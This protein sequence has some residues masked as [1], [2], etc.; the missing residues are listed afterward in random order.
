MKSFLETIKTRKSSR[1]FTDKKVP[2]SLVNKVLTLAT[3]APTPCNHQLWDFVVITE[4]RVKQKLV[5]EAASSTIILRAPVVI[6]IS[7]DGWNY[8][9][10]V[11]SGALAAENMHLAANYFGLG[12][13]AM[14]SYGS[15]K[16]IKEILGMPEN[17]VICCF[18][19]LGYPIKE[20]K[21]E[22]LVP[23]VPIKEIIH[24][25]H[26]QKKHFI[27][28][29]Y[30]PKNWSL[31][32]IKNYQERFCRKTWIGKA[33]D[34][35]SQHEL[36]IVKRELQNIK[37]PVTDLFSYDGMYLPYFQTNE[38][39]SYNLGKET[40]LYA[41]KTCESKNTTLK[42]NSKIYD[43]KKSLEKS[44][45]ISL[46]YKLE[47]LPSKTKERVL[48]Q[49]NN[50]LT[51]NGELLII[52]R[53]TNFFYSFF[54]NFIKFKFGDDIRKTG[55]YSFF[56]PYKPLS[57]NETKLQLQKAG[58]T[59]IKIRQYFL[60]PAF[61]EQ[62]Y[63]MYLQW[64]KSSGSTFLHRKRQENFLTKVF[65]I[66]IKVQGSFRMPFGNVVVIKAKK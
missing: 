25:N 31:N 13:L 2:I 26:F 49:A 1:R 38:I 41:K 39:T 16:K 62:A 24:L 23:R 33:M 37:S 10:A 40:S 27:S 19:L 35:L 50:S 14:N 34:I 9:E 6:V 5:N 22:P 17:N 51:Y 42:I 28:Y 58:F 11:Q 43:E 46:I 59:D 61:F 47:R 63:Q 45:T 57:I 66:I 55:I 12:G 8:K 53:K 36:E 60:F 7:Y 52:S 44:S 20:E 15:D 56:G 30:D 54:Y 29:S 18:F 48:K 21:Q 4:K 3:Y 65:D 64:K 32:D